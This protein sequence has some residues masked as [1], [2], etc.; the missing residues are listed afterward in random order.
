MQS[1]CS[2]AGDAERL[3]WD[4]ILRRGSPLA[5]FRAIDLTA[6]PLPVPLPLSPTTSVPARRRGV[7]A[8]AAAPRLGGSRTYADAA[9]AFAPHEDDGARG[10]AK[11]IRSIAGVPVALL[12]L[13]LHTDTGR[14]ETVTLRFARVAGD[15]WIRVGPLHLALSGA[16]TNGYG[17]L[18]VPLMRVAP[19]AAQKIRLHVVDTDD[20]TINSPWHVRFSRAVM[21]HVFAHCKAPDRARIEAV[22]S[23]LVS[24]SVAD[25]ADGSLPLPV[26][27]Q[28]S[29]ERG[30]ARARPRLHLRHHPPSVVQ[31]V[32]GVA[33]SVAAPVGTV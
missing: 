28:H 26:G 2:T 12:H 11:M 27:S 18:V 17:R 31:S 15:L 19:W 16:S 4:E 5:R 21:R 25:D 14:R 24:V 20:R 30:N 22:R 10:V 3:R 6:P 33:G 7:A 29:S 13:D 1:P 8:C 23:A 32:P 9:L